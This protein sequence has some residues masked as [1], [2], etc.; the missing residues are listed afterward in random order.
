MDKVF[1]K[2]V[3]IAAVPQ[4]STHRYWKAVHAG[5]NKAAHDLK[6]HGVTV[7]IAWKGPWRE[8][9]HEE[10]IGIVRDFIKSDVQG[11][12]LAPFNSR[13]LVAPVEEAA[14]AGI[15]TIVIDSA[16]DS[17]RI[18]SFIAS[19]NEKA[20]AVAADRMAGLLG[21][22]GKVLLLRYEQG[23]ASTNE[24]TKGFVERIKQVYHGMEVIS[25]DD[26][27][28][29]TR[30][31]ARQASA[32]LVARHAE[33]IQGIFTTNESST[34][35]MLMAL[36]SMQKAGKMVLVGFD[37]SDVYLDAMRYKQLHGLVV[38]DPFRM[39]ELAVKTI[40]D[41]L[42]GKPVQ[43]RVDTGVTMVTPENMDTPDAKR[44]LHPPLTEY[45]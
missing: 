20:G 41:H 33:Q 13:A 37:S 15:P 35:G 21:G 2:S 29:T 6:A 36:Q 22:K 19:D 30:E 9:N 38:Q 12:V 18:V 43:K 26:Y 10:Q 11:I 16:L 27:A 45:L 8:G 40:V 23:S 25:P 32:D 42:D 17:P 34:A 39:G 7:D 44:L 5:V 24:R 31:A 28:G 14:S 3:R 4:G 1:M